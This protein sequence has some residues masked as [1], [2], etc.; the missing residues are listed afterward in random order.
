MLEFRQH[1]L[2]ICSSILSEYTERYQLSDFKIQMDDP[3][4]YIQCYL[5]KLAKALMVLCLV[6]FSYHSF[7]EVP[8]FQ[9]FIPSTLGQFHPPLSHT[10]LFG[11]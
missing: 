9:V 1:G 5:M 7:S 3:L 10:L 8:F 2:E 4:F 6:L 11:M